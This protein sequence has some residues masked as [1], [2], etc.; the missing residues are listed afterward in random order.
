[1]DHLLGAAATIAGLHQRVMSLLDTSFDVM[2]A[3][4]RLILA[5]HSRQRPRSQATQR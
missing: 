5:T 1:M 3:R 4:G 2:G